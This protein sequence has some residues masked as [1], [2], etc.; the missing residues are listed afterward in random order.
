MN[1]GATLSEDFTN[2]RKVDVECRTDDGDV[3]TTSIIEPAG[4]CDLVCSCA[5]WQPNGGNVY[6][7]TKTF[8]F[9]GKSVKTQQ[10]GSGYSCGQVNVATGEKTF[11]DYLTVVRVT[12]WR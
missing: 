10:T 9:S 4:T 6:L 7:K 1:A 3:F 11:G 8:S 2:F 12:G 5:K